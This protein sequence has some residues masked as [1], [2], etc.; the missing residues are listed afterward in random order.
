VRV[1]SFIVPAHN[2]E[3]LLGRTLLAI[4]AAA[5]ALG[6]C[7]E[8]VVA[9]D[10]STDATAAIA[11]AHEAIVVAVSH[12][13]I[14]ATRNAGAR[15]ALGDLFFFVDADTLVTRAAVRA[16][17]RAVRGGRRRVYFPIRLRTA[18]LRALPAAA[19]QRSRPTT[20]ARRRVL[21]VLHARSVP[22]GRWFL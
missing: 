9:D 17:V 3:R 4:H 1:L 21:P 11:R 19:R 2:E 15:Q 14:A 18:T 7:Y 6:E 20:A 16:A 12:R 8:I 13:Q 10:A 22:S 5:R